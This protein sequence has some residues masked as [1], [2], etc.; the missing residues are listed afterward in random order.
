MFPTQGE[1]ILSMTL[2]DKYWPLSHS[3]LCN[4]AV[5]DSDASLLK[6]RGTNE[7]FQTITASGILMNRNLFYLG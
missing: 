7:P 5:I 1:A 3:Y 2:E 4:M 6:V